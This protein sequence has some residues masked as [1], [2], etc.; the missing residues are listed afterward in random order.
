MPRELPEL[1]STQRCDNQL[2]FIQPLL[3]R[4]GKKTHFSTIGFEEVTCSQPQVCESEPQ[5]GLLSRVRAV[6]ETH[7]GPAS[8]DLG[9]LPHHRGL[10]TLTEAATLLLI[11]SSPISTTCLPPNRNSAGPLT[12]PTWNNLLFP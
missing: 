2:G 7:S 3:L 9:A 12:G 1:H 4:L 10:S 6:L 5:G 8:L 11:P